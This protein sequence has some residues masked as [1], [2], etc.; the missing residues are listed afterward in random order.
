M[1]A[2]SSVSGHDSDH[3]DAA[4]GPRQDVGRSCL[5]PHAVNGHAYP[6]QPKV[7]LSIS[8]PKTGRQVVLTSAG[9][10]AEDTCAPY[11]DR[12]DTRTRATY[13][14]TRAESS[15]SSA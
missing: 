7:H 5:R 4:P 12:K 3:R 6:C 14:Q 8:S 10:R 13:A 1:K 15:R 2:L 9:Y 11:R